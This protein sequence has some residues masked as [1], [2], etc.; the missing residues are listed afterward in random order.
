MV[1]FGA[2][3]FADG[4]RKVGKEFSKFMSS[5]LAPRGSVRVIYYRASSHLK[6]RVYGIRKTHVGDGR[7]R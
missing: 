2:S 1:K 5:V 6:D 3:N 7:E 4:M